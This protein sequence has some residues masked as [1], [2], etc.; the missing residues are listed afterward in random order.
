METIHSWNGLPLDECEMLD[1]RD[2]LKYGQEELDRLQK[3]DTTQMKPDRRDR[4][5]NKRASMMAYITAVE[6]EIKLR[7]SKTQ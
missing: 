6:E 7:G 3:I 1:L 2:S 5:L 4:M